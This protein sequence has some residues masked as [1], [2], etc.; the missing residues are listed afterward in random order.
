MDINIIKVFIY[1]M[2][3]PVNRYMFPES[4]MLFIYLK[5]KFIIS[6]SITCRK[7]TVNPTH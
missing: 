3:L 4:H 2:D 6:K 1:K 7:R 5:S